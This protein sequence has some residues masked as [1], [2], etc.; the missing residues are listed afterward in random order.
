[1]VRA[2]EDTGALLRRLAMGF[3]DATRSGHDNDLWS[4]QEAAEQ[5]WQIG[6]RHADLALLMV[7]L[8]LDCHAVDAAAAA[9]AAVPAG[10]GDPDRAD[11]TGR[12]AAAARRP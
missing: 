4:V 10:C 6:V 9:L 1:M 2:A 8:H 5:A 7:Q 12:A 3:A 11:A